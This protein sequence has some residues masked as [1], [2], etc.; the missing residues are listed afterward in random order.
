VVNEFC[1]FIL[2]LVRLEKCRLLE[3]KCLLQYVYASK[4]KGVLSYSKYLT[5][6]LT[7]LYTKVYFEISK[8][9]LVMKVP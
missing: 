3:C 9:V 8:F 5:F 2:G 1:G 6:Y 4:A 7:G